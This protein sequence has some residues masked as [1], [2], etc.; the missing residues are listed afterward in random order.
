MPGTGVAAIGCM[1]T[2]LFFA[3]REGQTRRIAQRIA[4]DL[5]AAGAAVDLFDLGASP[6]V[7]LSDYASACVASSVHLGRHERAA[8]AFVKRERAALERMSA[9]FVSVSLSEAGAQD[10]KR[11]E[12]ERRQSAAEVQQVIDG[13]VKETG[14]R[15]ARVFPVAGALAY[16]RYNVLVRFVMKLI[17][18][19]T[20]GPTDTTR[21]HELTDWAAVDRIAE[22]IRYADAASRSD[23]PAV[24]AASP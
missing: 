19:R 7:V 23:G 17:A 9:V 8:V 6:A 10:M 1:K 11:S 13:F 2:A 24:G 3:S 16:T 12:S 18:R 4:A 15:P 14:W 21:D 5:Q 20:G 22:T